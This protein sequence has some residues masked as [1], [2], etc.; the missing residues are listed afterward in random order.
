MAPCHA[1]APPDPRRALAADALRRELAAAVT[2]LRTEPG[3]RAWLHAC[4]RLPRYS[5]TNVL[6]IVAQAHRRRL[7]PSHAASLR[8][9]ARLGYRVRAGE[10]G[11][12]IRRPIT[13]PTDVRRLDE[14]NDDAPRRT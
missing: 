8:T 7:D 5:P 6:L 1:L 9:W 12:L 3:F 13:V 14:Q 4:A 2:E 10:R 11:L